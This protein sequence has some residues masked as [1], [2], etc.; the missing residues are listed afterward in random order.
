V[1]IIVLLVNNL[2]SHMFP[3]PIYDARG[4]KPFA[5]PTDLGNMAG[6]L[7]LFDGEA[8]EGSPALVAYTVTSYKTAKSNDGINLS[9]NI[10]WIAILAADGAVIG[11]V[12]QFIVYTI[13]VN[14]SLR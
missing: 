6:Q 14:C 10:L 12:P 1:I 8:P 13:F 9:F 11:F 7:P 4:K 2:C 5:I 3:V